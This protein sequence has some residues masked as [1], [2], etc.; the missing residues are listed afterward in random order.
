MLVKLARST[1][2]CY[3]PSL[4]TFDYS[5]EG[6]VETIRAVEGIPE[7][8]QKVVAQNTGKAASSTLL[9]PDAELSMY[10]TELGR[11]CSR[12]CRF[13]AAG[14][15]YRPPRLWNAEEIIEGLADRPQD[16]KRVGLLG[17]EMA[18]ND[19]L[20]RIAEYLES[21]SCSLSFSSLRADRISD[22][23]LSLLSR[24]GLKSAAIAPDGC[25]ERLRRV[26]NKGLAENDLLAAGKK[27]VEAGIVHLK[28]YV[29]IGL[30][31]EGFEDLRELVQFI[32]RLQELILPV[33]R[34]RGQV[35]R[36]TLSVNSF[37]P[38]PWTPFQ[39][40]SFGGQGRGE[41]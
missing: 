19:V 16:M 38:K 28:L 37:V 30:P 8:V 20:D 13:C 11:G 4:Y 21:E 24:S 14:F 41:R 32:H 34:K 35:C 15:I 27:L 23:L 6:A 5:G 36:I 9:S 29:M 2:G 39:F 1:V 17:M 18:D 12:G 7:R 10:M 33:G 26:I 22:R 40:I 3:V 31:T 25:S